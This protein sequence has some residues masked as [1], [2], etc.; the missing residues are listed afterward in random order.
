MDCV[1][2][3]T[4]LPNVPLI[5]SPFRPAPSPLSLSGPDQLMETAELSDH[6]MAGVALLKGLVGLDESATLCQ[7]DGTHSS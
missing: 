3:Q 5:P 2:L 1:W 4:I 7:A 6:F